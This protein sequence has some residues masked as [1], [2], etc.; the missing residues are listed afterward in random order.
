M[1]ALQDSYRFERLLTI[2]GIVKDKDERGIVESL[3]EVSDLLI[4]A[5]PVTHK[6]LDTDSV[7][8]AARSAHDHVLLIRDIEEA[9]EYADE[10]SGPADMILVTGSFYT[11]S[12]ARSSIM[13]RWS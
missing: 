1:K 10:N 5:E 7:I 12:P 4:V 11:T 6:D 8:A 2:V 9:L 13:E 3:A